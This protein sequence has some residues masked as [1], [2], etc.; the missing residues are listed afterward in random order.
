MTG[1]EKRE[2]QGRQEASRRGERDGQWFEQGKG[3]LVRCVTVQS[4]VIRSWMER[5]EGD[6]TEADCDP[7]GAWWRMYLSNATPHADSGC[8]EPLGIADIFCGAGGLALGIAQFAYELGRTPV[9]EFIVDSDADAVATFTAN[10]DVRVPIR[11]SATSL[12]DY[13]IKGHGERAKFAYRPEAIADDVGSAAGRIELLTAGPPCQGHSNLNNHSRRRDLR[14]HLMLA[15]PAFAVALRIPMIV[16]ENVP[17][18]MNDAT[19]TIATVRALLESEGYRVQ[20]GILAADEM[21]WPQTRRRYFMVASRVSDPIPLSVVTETLRDTTPKGGPRPVSWLL[22]SVDPRRKRAH[23]AHA[24]DA[25]TAHSNENQ[26]RINWLFDHNSY[27][28]PES[29]RP[30]CHRDGTTY[31]AVYGRMRPNRPAPTIT[32]GFTSPGRGRFVHPTE[33]RTVTPREAATIQGFPLAYRFV[34]EAGGVPSRTKLAKWIG[35]AVPM[36]L[37]YA[38]ALS[39]MGNGEGD[40]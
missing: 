3:R 19:G 17:S 4:C 26:A 37:G 36:P 11:R 28:L 30:E 15:V 29:R 18:V 14:N 7:L 27:D 10:H 2:A 20:E 31:G 32:T 9:W 21:G 6:E 8:G 13:R 5:A 12:I 38:A 40:R 34:T 25:P 23:G 39:V 35:D 16:V 22:G 1:Q 33:R 24:L